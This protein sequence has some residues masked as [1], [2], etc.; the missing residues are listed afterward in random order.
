MLTDRR[1]NE[2]LTS[3][4]RTRF[5]TEIGPPPKRMTSLGFTELSSA[6]CSAAIIENYNVNHT[7][8]RVGADIARHQTAT[9]GPSTGARYGIQWGQ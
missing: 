1:V 5:P 2:S 6:R 9:N 3:L 4:A 8:D 7:E